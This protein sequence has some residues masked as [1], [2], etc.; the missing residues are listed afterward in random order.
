MRKL[1]IKLGLLLFISIGLFSCDKM[2]KN[3]DGK[4][5]SIRLFLVGQWITESI[6]KNPSFHRSGIYVFDFSIN[7]T[8]TYYWYDLNNESCSFNNGLLTLPASATKKKVEPT[9]KYIFIDGELFVDGHSWGYI[10]V[11]ND[12]LL[13]CEMG[14]FLRIK[15]INFK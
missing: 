9:F 12:D 3:D 14:R 11:I 4:D 7:G 6:V 1:S 5:G 15:R 10:D 2:K 13:S 8:L